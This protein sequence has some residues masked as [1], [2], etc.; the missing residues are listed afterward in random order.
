MIRIERELKTNIPLNSGSA[1]KK[2]IPETSTIIPL[3]IKI[4]IKNA[5]K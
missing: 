1:E 4:T 2:E 5:S 3:M